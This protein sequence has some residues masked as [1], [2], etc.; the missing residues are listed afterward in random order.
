MVV[1]GNALL[2]S[3]GFSFCRGLSLQSCD[4][5]ESID[6]P[7]FVKRDRLIRLRVLLA[8]QRASQLLDT[9]QLEMQER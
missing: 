2:A 8:M 5:G 7:T 1:D 3:N 6:V 9:S 4:H